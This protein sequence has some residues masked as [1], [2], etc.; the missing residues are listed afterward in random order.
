MKI[1]IF[2]VIQSLL[3]KLGYALIFRKKLEQLI[4]SQKNESKF[5]VAFAVQ[6]YQNKLLLKEIPTGFVEYSKSQF[7]QDLLALLVSNFKKKWVFCRI[8]SYKR[9]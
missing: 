9:N 3:G 7:G 6:M 1:L 5:A 4:E 2:N 8:W